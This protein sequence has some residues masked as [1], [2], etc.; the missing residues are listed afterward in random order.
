MAGIL[1][2]AAVGA[3][4]MQNKDHLE[5][6]YDLKKQGYID[7][8]GELTPK[9]Y[10]EFQSKDGAHKRNILNDLFGAMVDTQEKRP[11]LNYDEASREFAI[12]TTKAEEKNWW[13]AVL[14][15]DIMF[16]DQLIRMGIDV[17]VVSQED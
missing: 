13:Q 9:F 17:V 15:R 3:A 1:S 14:D 4:A 6:E 12:V 16:R 2:G 5:L 10:E 8:K 11:K 7:T